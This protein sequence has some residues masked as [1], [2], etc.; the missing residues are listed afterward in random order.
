MKRFFSNN[1]NRALVFL[2]IAAMLVSGCSH[3]FRFVDAERTNTVFEEFYELEDDSADC[4]FFGSSVTQRGYITPVAYHEYGI[5]AYLLASGTQPFWMIKYFMKETLKTQKPRLFVVELKGIC[6]SVDWTGDVHIRRM[7]DNMKLSLNKIGAIRAIRRYFPEDRN[8]IDSTGLSYLFPIIKYHSQWSPN[9]R[10]K[11]FEDVDYYSGYSPVAK[12]SFNVKSYKTFAYD[13]HTLQIDSRTEEAL[14][15]LLDYCDTLDGTDVLFVM[16]P[17]QASAD[18]MGKMN[19]AKRIIEE[20][21]Y[22]CLNM[23]DDEQ[24]AGMGLDDRTCY[25]DKSHMNYYGALIYTKYFFGYLKE[26]YGL[27]DRRGSKECA[28]WESEYE[29]LMNDLETRYSVRYTDMMAE[30]DEIRSEGK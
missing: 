30:I 12:K 1:L 10:M 29:R 11:E 26:R 20:R 21:G 5:P 17:Y 8:G 28:K 25:H 4:I 14:N 6:K 13:D 18:G 15:D 2:I 23:L 27:E 3:V 24:R 19:Y 7:L 16:P 22:E 9:K